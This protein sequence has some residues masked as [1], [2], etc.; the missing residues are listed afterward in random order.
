MTA[1][2]PDT[3]PTPDSELAPFAEPSPTAEPSPSPPKASAPAKGKPPLGRPRGKDW[4]VVIG[5]LLFST[6][7]ALLRPSGGPASTA[8][9]EVEVVTVRRGDV[10]ATIEAPGTVRAGSETGAGAPF[11][12]KIVELVKDEG[13][14]VEE[15]DVLFRLDPQDKREALEEA[16]LT[17]ARNL[18]ALAEAQAEAD[19]AQRQ[20]ADISREP[21]DLVEAKLRERQ[22]KLQLERTETELQAATTRLNRA[23]AMRDEGIGTEINVETNQDAL[24]VAENAKRIA[25]S[26]LRL[27]QETIRFRER[28]WEEARAAREKDASIALR[29]LERAKADRDTSAVAL[30]RAQR[31]LERCEIRSP[32]TG[33]V[34]GRGVNLGDQVTRATGDTTHY[35]VSDLRLLVVYLDVDEGDVVHAAP[36]QPATVTVSAYPNDRFAGEVID[37]GYRADTTSD[38]ATFR[39]RVVITEQREDRVLRPGMSARVTIETSREDDVLRVPLQAVVQREVR[40]LPERLAASVEGRS[41]DA[42]VDA[43]FVAV[44][45]KAELVLLPEGTRDLEHALAPADLDPAA[46]IVVGPFSQLNGLEDGR[47]VRPK[48]VQD[49]YPDDE[50]EG[51][52]AEVESATAGSE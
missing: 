28:T 31:D 16:R 4:A 42:L 8:G 27:A 20:M 43:F 46:Q 7:L 6:L 24:E 44:D 52:V 50:P 30:E 37:V 45:K 9:T 14:Q 5:V 10:I 19:E 2:S 26:E 41:E 1:P 49:F 32:L 47:R 3:E 11:E 12:G 36:G 38:V 39:V 23:E 51:D 18:A 21:S 33:V 17:H 22:S 15:G 29:R 25:Q 34:T 48:E 35:I 13:D 40:E